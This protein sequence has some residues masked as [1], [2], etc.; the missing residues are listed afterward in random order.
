[1]RL[2]TY[3]ADPGFAA[4]ARIHPA[5]HRKIHVFL[6]GVEIRGVETADEKRGYIMRAKT[7]ADGSLIINP[8]ENDYVREEL[9]GVVTITGVEREPD[10]AA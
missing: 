8:A 4:W 9:R 10:N 3:K 1:M 7:A 5:D 2:S 6:D